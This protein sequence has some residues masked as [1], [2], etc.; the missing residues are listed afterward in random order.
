VV[1]QSRGNIVTCVTSSAKVLSRWGGMET[2]ARMA[3]LVP[4][5]AQDRRTRRGWVQI[6]D[7]GSRRLDGHTGANQRIGVQVFVP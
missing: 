4:T 7:R 6:A 1:E 2:G 5:I 3:P